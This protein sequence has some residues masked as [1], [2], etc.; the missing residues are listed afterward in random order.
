MKS[1][2]G[3]VTTTFLGLTLALAATTGCSSDSNNGGGGSGGSTGGSAGFGGS[4]GGSGGSTG[5]SAGS[6]GSTG[7]SGGSMGGSA[8]T[9]GGSTG[10]TGGSMGGAGG[11]GG[12]MG[13]AGGSSG[14]GGSTP[15]ALT[16]KNYLSWCSVS[17]A[18]GT[19]KADAVQTVCVPAGPVDL[20]ATA[21]SGFELGSTPW[22]NTDGDSGNGDKGT[23]TGSGQAAKSSTTE[24]T[25]GSTDCVWVCCPTVGQ[26][27]CP[28]TDQCP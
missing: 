2:S 15:V 21:L 19:A 8:G 20:S 14:C 5:G 6:G 11:S 12:S 10:G 23:V 26:S 27:D 25:S 9:D 24:T 4:S 13:G 16:V 7:G 28:T 18:S 22:H 1:F 3:T 17:V